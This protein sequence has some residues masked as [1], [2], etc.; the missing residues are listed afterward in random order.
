MTSSNDRIPG[1]TRDDASHPPPCA[2]A[3]LSATVGG[4]D[5]DGGNAGR[6]Q[7]ER[8][9]R[10]S[11]PAA[12]EVH[13]FPLI[14]TLESP[15]SVGSDGPHGHRSSPTA[16][17]T[18][19]RAGR[20]GPTRNSAMAARAPRFARQTRLTS[21]WEDPITSGPFRA[22]QP[23]RRRRPGCDNEAREERASAIRGSAAGASEEATVAREPRTRGLGAARA[24]VHYSMSRRGPLAPPYSILGGRES[25]RDIGQGRSLV[26]DAAVL[27][28]LGLDQLSS[29]RSR[30]D[31][32]VTPGQARVRASARSLARAPVF[33]GTT[34]V[35]GA[36]Q[37]GA[38]RM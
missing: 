24:C 22:T 15:P 27:P 34:G 23:E 8:M 13:S 18:Q 33:A 30:R 7:A 4:R 11:S 29:P 3:V 5:V 31:C 12:A 16:F 2:V 26:D 14:V 9:D 1:A 35:A 32:S 37:V 20:C 17:T 36:R 38:R 28:I 19:P 6:L 10:M 21:A 25:N